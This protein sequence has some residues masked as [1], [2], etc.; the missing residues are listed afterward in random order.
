MGGDAGG[1]HVAP[2]AVRHGGG[3]EQAAEV[4]GLLL[5]VGAHVHNLLVG[6]QQLAAQEGVVHAPRHRTD[7]GGGDVLPD[8]LVGGEGVGPHPQ[9][10]VEGL[11]LE[12]LLPAGEAPPAVQGLPEA[13]QVVQRQGG[14]PPEVLQGDG[15][16]SGPGGVGTEEVGVVGGAPAADAAPPEH[17]VEVGP[18]QGDGDLLHLPLGPVQHVGGGD[19]PPL[20]G[21]D[22]QPE[23]R[24]GPAGE[25]PRPGPVA[26]AAQD[27]LHGR[28]P[29]RPGGEPRAGGVVPHRGHRQLL[30]RRHL[31]E[32][33]LQGGAG[34]RG[35]QAGPLPPPPQAVGHG[36]DRLRPLP[37]QE[38]GGG[39][40]RVKGP[41]GGQVLHQQHLDGLPL[42]DAKAAEAGAVLPGLEHRLADDEGEDPAPAEEPVHGGVGDERGDVLLGEAPHRPPGGEQP[43]GL[44][45][46]LRARP[47]GLRQVLPVD[48]G[49][50]AG[51]HVRPV[52]RLGPEAVGQ[53]PAPDG[54]GGVPD[55]VRRSRGGGSLRRPEHVGPEHR[56]N[57]RHPLLQQVQHRQQVVGLGRQHRQGVDVQAPHRVQQGRQAAAGPA[58]D[59]DGLKQEGAGAAG[60]VQD[61][62]G[63]RVL[64]PMSLQGLAQGRLRQPVRGVVLPQGV[65]QLPG[66]QG[67]VHQPDVV[68]AGGAGPARRG[69]VGG[70]LPPHAV[71]HPAEAPLQLEQGPAEA[72]LADVVLNPP[73][74]GEVPH[75]DGGVP[76]VGGPQQVRHGGL[77]QQAEIRLDGEEQ[78]YHGLPLPA[79]G[80][81]SV[82]RQQVR[83]VQP[84]VAGEIGRH[85]PVDQAEVRPPEL[86][87]Q[88]GF[89]AGA[90][91]KGVDVCYN[92]DSR[93]AARGAGLP[94]I[95][96]E[97][98]Q[99]E[100]GG[101]PL[102]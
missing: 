58:L 75:D 9:H 79:G 88:S 44:P 93:E 18:L 56:Q 22:P 37:G 26:V 35:Q 86:R 97:G 52:Q 7:E 78:P 99:V 65:A 33:L 23:H 62:Q 102:K 91:E 46:M 81:Q 1:V 34:V 74:P 16:Y 53:F 24:V 49:G 10:P 20:G 15:A 87:Q 43:V 73:L 55:E 51:D 71:H 40:R 90:L 11:A 89:W 59:G 69:P 61:P 36:V 64:P 2:D 47:V 4:V 13:E 41:Q 57:D 25:H 48:P 19:P 63:R 66:D 45:Q 50:V 96:A 32:D 94:Q 60:G 39:A 27:P 77:Q 38:E 68:P 54:G 70:Q 6:Q 3:A 82:P 72:V 100:H 101:P 76:G 14:L 28:Q 5:A 95:C 83:R 85:V 8:H 67:L 92:G 17:G 30:L 84:P 80:V 21:E 42:P 98:V 31:G 12:L 29:V